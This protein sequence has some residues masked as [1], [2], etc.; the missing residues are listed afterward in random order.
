MGWLGVK[1]DMGT[2]R[3]EGGKVEMG[4]EAGGLGV[5]VEMGICGGREGGR[6]GVKVDMWAGGGGEE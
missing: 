2:G 6:L 4:T 3:R 1:V 5:K